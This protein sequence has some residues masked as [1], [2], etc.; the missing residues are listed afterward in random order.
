M[1][2]MHAPR[3]HSYT[4]LKIN[5]PLREHNTQRE[6]TSNL[7]PAQKPRDTRKRIR[8]ARTIRRT[9]FGHSGICTSLGELG[10]SPEHETWVPVTPTARRRDPTL[11]ACPATN[12]LPCACIQPAVNRCI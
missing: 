2:R 3:H 7:R 4:Q 10:A 8:E 9:Q 6:Q 11:A 5:Q 1:Y 12:V